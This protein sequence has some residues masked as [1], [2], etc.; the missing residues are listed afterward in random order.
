MLGAIQAKNHLKATNAP[1][2][3][4]V[5]H[6]ADRQIPDARRS[7]FRSVKPEST[8]PPPRA[9]RYLRFA[10]MMSR[11]ACALKRP[12]LVQMHSDRG[13]AQRATFWTWRQC[14]KPTRQ[15]PPVLHFRSVEAKMQQFQ[16]RSMP[17]SSK[18][19]S[20]ISPSIWR[21]LKFRV[22]G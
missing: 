17:E 18:I 10:Q 7:K 14:S 16:P 4:F 13:L 11:V 6:M 20:G 2:R 12:Y 21:N 8:T 1:L 22:P 19:S 15:H 3:H 9:Q 5:E